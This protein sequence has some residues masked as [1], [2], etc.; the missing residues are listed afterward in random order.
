V[1]RDAPVHDIGVQPGCDGIDVPSP[2]RMQ[3]VEH[4]LE[5]HLAHGMVS[6]IEVRVNANPDNDGR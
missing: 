1:R 2:P 4:G 3:M 5:A 6:V